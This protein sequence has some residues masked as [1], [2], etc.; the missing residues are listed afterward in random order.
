MK[1]T[2]KFLFFLLTFYSLQVFAQNAILVENKKLTV[3]NLGGDNYTVGSNAELRISTPVSGNG[4]VDLVSDS[5][6]LILDNVLPSRA[7][8]LHFS[9]ITVNGQKAVNNVNVRVTNYLR[10][11]V[12]MPHSSTFEALSLFK[13]PNF[14]GDEMKCIPYKYYKEAEL[15][16]FNNT[17]SSFKLKKGYMATFAQNQDGTGYSKVFIAD[18]QDVE[19]SS[20]QFALD[21]EVSFVRVFRWRYTDKKGF[22]S[23]GDFA[24][25]NKPALL[26]KS[27]WFYNWGPTTTE[28]LTDLEFVPMK[29]SARTSTEPAWKTIL[30][31]NNP[32]HL[33]GF[34]EP[35]STGQ[36]NMTT[37]EQLLHWPKMMESGMRLGSPAPTNMA[38]FYDFMEQCDKR[39]YRVDFVALHDY[40]TGTAQAFYNFCK[41]VHDR[42]GRPIWVTEF[43]WGGTWSTITP[44]YAEAAARINEIIEKYDTEGIIE[45]YAIFS[46]DEAVNDTG[47]AQNRAVFYTPALPDYNFTP[48]GEVYRD[49]VAPMAFNSAEQIDIPFKMIAPINLKGENTD[50]VTTKLVWQ[51]IID[52]S[53]GTFKIERSFNGGAFS[54][55]ASISGNNA[56]YNDNVGTIGY[57]VYTY[58]IASLNAFMG[59]STAVSA[60]VDVLPNGKQN[61]ARFKEVDAS[62]T[63]SAPFPESKAVDGNIVSNDSR[64][65]SK[66]GAFPAT[67][68]I[69][70]TDFYLVDELV[71]YCGASGYNN[72]ITNF[73]FQY[74]SNNKWVDAISETTN[75]SAV[76]RKSF[77]EVKTNKLRLNVNSTASNAVRLYEIEVYGKEFNTLGIAENNSYEYKFKIYPNPTS[78]VISVKGENNVE[79]IVVFDLNAKV[80]MSN[81]NSNN[82]NVSQLPVGTYIIRVNDKETFK[83]IKI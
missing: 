75:I 15:G 46:F 37:N 5:G 39:N 17:V 20:L 61:I 70:L 60:T 24:Q 68:E 11:C 19:V 74:W 8:I 42:T 12:I 83:F 18:N 3:V 47:G 4:K 43:N 78:S 77:T 73:Q 16:G 25:S 57:G 27:G 48:I 36:A 14:V 21:N 13:D 56:S 9:Y 45:R 35:Q 79:S 76:Y 66:P 28:G 82:I 32:S 1:N 44:T 54:E 41:T 53:L 71:M 7:P 38:L 23:G 10:G 55:I 29:Y 30:D 33:L 65:V 64:W 26:T 80:L 50:G 72:P 67:L 69:K 6:W 51:N 22:G 59:N 58:K 40:G 52:N 81:K 2:T 63:H 49:N 31:L 62:S 34:N